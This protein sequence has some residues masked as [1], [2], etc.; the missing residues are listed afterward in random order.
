MDRCMKFIVEVLAKGD[1]HVFGTNLVSR[2]ERTAVYGGFFGRPN[3]D[4]QTR[5]LKPTLLFP[6]RA[7][8]PDGSR[9]SLVYA[10]ITKRVIN[11]H[12]CGQNQT[13][14]RILRSDT[15]NSRTTDY[16]IA[17]FN[18]LHLILSYLKSRHLY[19][20][21]EVM[22]LKNWKLSVPN[23]GP[24]TSDELSGEYVCRMAAML[25]E[26]DLND[27]DSIRMGTRRQLGLNR[28]T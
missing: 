10:N 26:Q 25:I 13:V 22:D 2:L 24:Q 28:L 18:C 27:E 19:D 15:M 5:L 4:V 16:M 9:W 14:A 7:P 6:V 12:D 11:Y 1:A 23:G 20:T 3:G 8:E 21:G 17:R